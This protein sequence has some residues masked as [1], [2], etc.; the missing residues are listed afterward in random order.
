[1]KVKTTAEVKNW[2][3]VDRTVKKVERSDKTKDQCTVAKRS[4]PS[5]LVAS[6]M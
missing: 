4:G 6:S 3:R 5:K 2:Q 1:M